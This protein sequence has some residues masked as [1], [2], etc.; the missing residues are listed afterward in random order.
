MAIR[1]GRCLLR[2]R[3]RQAGMTQSELARRVNLTPQMI[4]HYTN[5][6]KVMSLTH[7]KNIADVLGCRIEDLYEWEVIR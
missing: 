2:M 7:A 1:P 4:G 5:N 6:R 3:L